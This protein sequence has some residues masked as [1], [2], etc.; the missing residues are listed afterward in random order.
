[1]SYVLNY[2]YEKEYSYTEPDLLASEDQLAIEKVYY[3]KTSEIQEVMSKLASHLKPDEKLAKAIRQY[4]IAFMTKNP[5][6]MAFFGGN[7]TGVHVVRFTSK[8]RDT[9]FSDVCQIDEFELEEALHQ[10]ST[11]DPNWNVASD[12]LN[13][14][15][16]WLIHVY[17]T[18]KLPDRVKQ[19]VCLEIAL[20][21]HYRFITSVL[22]RFFPY[23]VDPKL[24]EAVYSQMTNKYSIKEYGS[25]QALLEAKCSELISP[26]SIHYKTLINYSPDTEIVYMLNDTQGRIKKLM[27]N[28]AALFAEVKLKGNRVRTTGMLLEADGDYILKD[29]VNGLQKYTQYLHSVVADPRSF[30]KDEILELLESIVPAAPIKLVRHTLEWISNNYLY[31]SGPE[32][33]ELIDKTILHSFEYTASSRTVYKASSDLPALISRLKGIY[34]ASRGYGDLLLEIRDTG[35]KVVAL[36]GATKN[37][38]LQVSVRT[39]VLLYLV[40]RAY[41]SAHYARS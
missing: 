1:M 7:L 4:R 30:I 36:S 19:A 39:A 3:E 10:C 35:E 32:I 8:D 13:H 33:K 18:S 31:Y 14:L 17:L 38:S 40:I 11:I 20:V 27:K 9:F 34:T 5:E 41:T 25:W 6:H 28:I 29:K 2:R 21:L 16:F 26:K 23:P 15:G 24:G 22:Y 12:A 37:K